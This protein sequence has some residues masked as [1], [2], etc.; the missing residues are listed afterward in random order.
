MYKN[1]Y[2]IPRH[3]ANTFLLLFEGLIVPVLGDF[4]SVLT[5]LVI[6]P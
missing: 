6:D 4:M 1:K 2:R 3:L 5:N